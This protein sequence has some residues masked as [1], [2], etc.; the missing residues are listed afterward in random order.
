M[1]RENQRAIMGLAVFT[2]FLVSA[3]LLGNWFLSNTLNRPIE[4]VP[5]LLKLIVH[6]VSITILFALAKK[7]FVKL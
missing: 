3:I 4:E 1:M 5:T 6:G 7:Y 2:V